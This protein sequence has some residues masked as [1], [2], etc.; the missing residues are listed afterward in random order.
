M[1]ITICDDKHD[2]GM[3]AANLGAN[4]IREAISKKG[5]AT[6]VLPTGLSQT[7]MYD[8]LVK[9]SIP[10]EKVEAFH[11]HEYVG[12]PSSNPAS[13]R[14][15]L[16]SHFIGKAKNLK[17]FHEI[18][19]NAPDLNEELKR[20]NHLIQDKEIDVLFLGIG[21][22]G[23]IA[24]NDPPANLETND[25]FILVSLEERCRRQQVS[26]KWFASLEEVPTQAISMSIR[27][28]L[29]ANNVICSVPDQ[30]KARAVAMCLYDQ[31][32]PYAP[33]TVLRT[34]VA[35]NLFLDKP[36]SMLILGDRR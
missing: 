23:Y 36:S 30:R 1:R 5:S 26:E 18:E 17:A 14:S 2:L 9:E 3:Q 32:S 10:W 22:N 13:F 25:P 11:L 15:Y 29:K 20:L 16:E 28:I 8:T 19:A 7:E 33:C 12:L 21:E 6:I 35:C 34:K 4:L 24:F 27:Q 31:V